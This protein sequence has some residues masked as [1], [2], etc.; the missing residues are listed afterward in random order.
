MNLLERRSLIERV[1]TYLRHNDLLQGY[2]PQLAMPEKSS[3][4]WCLLWYCIHR[5]DSLVDV[6]RRENVPADDLLT[7]LQHSDTDFARALQLF[8]EETDG[9]VSQQQLK[10]M[11]QTPWLEREYFANGCPPTCAHYLALIDHKAVIPVAICASLNGLDLNVPLVKQFVVSIGRTAQLTDDLLDLRDDMA[12]GRL[13]ITQEEL[14]LLDL[15]A[16]EILT[17]LDTVA[18]LRNKWIMAMSWSGFEAAHELQANCFA[19]AARSWIEGIWRL[20]AKGRS[21]P[22]DPVLFENNLDVAHYMGTTS[23]PFDLSPISELLKY[24]L[25]HRLMVTFLRHYRIFDYKEAQE[26]FAVL[27]GNIELLLEI[28]GIQLPSTHELLGRF[29]PGSDERRPISL[30]ESLGLVALRHEI[31]RILKDAIVDQRKNGNGA[32][33]NGAQPKIAVEL[34]T[35]LVNIHH[36][37]DLDELNLARSVLVSLLPSGWPIAQEL[38]NVGFDSLSILRDHQHLFQKEVLNWFVNPRP[39]GH[40]GHDSARSG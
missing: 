2:L 35:D 38:V 15:S 34:L 5:I 23:L 30:D 32:S 4:W 31:P 14:A 12:H 26:V 3:E 19:L 28:A 16:S 37:I 22:L 29:T 21:A 9:L 40:N 25:T 17:N 1:R 8:L 13:F 24:R 27:D 10:E 36:A 18:R 39:N 20:I 6:G 33:E 11:Y 7:R